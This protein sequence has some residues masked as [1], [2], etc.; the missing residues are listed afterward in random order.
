LDKSDIVI[1]ALPDA[2][3]QSASKDITPYLR[4]ETTVI[5][6]DPAAAYMGELTTKEG[7]TYVVT[8]PCHPALFSEQETEEARK[9]LFG[10][11]AAKQDIVIALMQGDEEKFLVAEQIC[12]EMFAPVVTCH[13]ITVEQMAILEPA[14]A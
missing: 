12:K 14:A 10:G 6:L 11:I 5:I 2:L 1:L 4:E 7:C 3:L 13:R 8:H 9:D